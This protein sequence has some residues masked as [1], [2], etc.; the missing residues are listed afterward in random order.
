MRDTN[1]AIV[2]NNTNHEQHK[3]NHEEHKGLATSVRRNK[4][5]RIEG[6]ATRKAETHDCREGA[7]RN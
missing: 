7:G 5:K 1:E 2:E 6:I 3:C 4:L